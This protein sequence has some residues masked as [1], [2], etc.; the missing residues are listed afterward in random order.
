MDVSQGSTNNESPVSTNDTSTSMMN[1][2]QYTQDDSMKINKISK[3]D[4]EMLITQN[5]E[6]FR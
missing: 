1:V 6:K 3:A 2:S 5:S 4:I